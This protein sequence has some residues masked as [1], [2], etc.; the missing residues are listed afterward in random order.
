MQLVLT[1]QKQQTLALAA[2]ESS[3]EQQQYLLCQCLNASMIMLA[4]L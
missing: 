4:V 1:S 2:A 3:V